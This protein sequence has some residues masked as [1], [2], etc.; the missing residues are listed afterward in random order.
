VN[1]LFIDRTSTGVPLDRIDPCDFESLARPLCLGGK[2][3][4]ILSH[5]SHLTSHIC[6]K[7]MEQV[8]IR[9][10]E[11]LLNHIE[12]PLLLPSCVCLIVEVDFADKNVNRET[13]QDEEVGIIRKVIL[14]RLALGGPSVFAREG[15]GGLS[16]PVRLRSRLI[17]AGRST[18]GVRSEGHWYVLLFHR[19]TGVEMIS[20]TILMNIRLPSLLWWL[21]A[22][23]T[24]QHAIIAA[25]SL[26]M[27]QRLVNTRQLCLSRVRCVEDVRKR[28]LVTDRG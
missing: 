8:E 10:L 24:H 11:K 21:A 6:T 16:M 15:K 4:L 28:T 22:P 12:L 5:I 23:F 20:Q 2:S 3:Q 13:G 27:S 26:T 19:V 9:I 7:S 25:E 17:W 1:W 18:R 14:K